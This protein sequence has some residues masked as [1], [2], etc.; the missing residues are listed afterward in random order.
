MRSTQTNKSLRAQLKTVLEYVIG[1]CVVVFFVVLLTV[2]FSFVGTLICAALAGMMMGS[3]RFSCW[4]SCLVSLIFPGV[5]AA[6]L[7]GYRAELPAG[8]I[9]ILCLLCAGVFWATY[10]V[11]YALSYPA[12]ASSATSPAADE[13]SSA[14]SS[15]AS[16]SATTV[17]VPIR[18]AVAPMEQA[19]TGLR[20][21]AALKS[22][23]LLGIWIEQSGTQHPS[24][25]TRRLEIGKDRVVLSMVDPNGV[26]L[27]RAEARF[28]VNGPLAEH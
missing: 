7:L 25:Y 6:V 18:D 12:T 19:Q 28:Q 15:A 3:V 13:A 22:E 2:I 20:T 26:E 23:D 10:G 4:R 16:Q 17:G 8:Q 24:A 11:M 14:A 9:C 21:A 1:W 27:S 5:I